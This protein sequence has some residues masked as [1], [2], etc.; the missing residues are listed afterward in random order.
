MTKLHGRTS[1]PK[2]FWE[3][4]SPLIVDGECLTHIQCI[5]SIDDQLEAM[6]A[7]YRALAGMDETY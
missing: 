2:G 4:T 5:R 7:N 1:K 6:E 3:L